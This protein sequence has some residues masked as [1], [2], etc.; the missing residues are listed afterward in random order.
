MIYQAK[1]QCHLR[2]LPK[3]VDRHS[4]SRIVMRNQNG[5]SLSQNQDMAMCIEVC[6]QIAIWEMTNYE[7]T[8][9]ATGDEGTLKWMDHMSLISCAWRTRMFSTGTCRA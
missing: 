1:T 7:N 3:S 2:Q 4:R 5:D 8:Y 6:G 9:H